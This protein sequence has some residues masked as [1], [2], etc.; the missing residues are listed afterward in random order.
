MQQTLLNTLIV[1][2]AT[3]GGI[4]IIAYL[5]TI[6]DLW[7]GKS[8]ANTPSYILWTFCGAIASLYGIFILHDFLYNIVTGL[9]FLSCATI[10]ILRLRLSK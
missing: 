10:L 5:P 4:S 8:S 2:Y 7:Q 9:N 1:L 3:T 6:I